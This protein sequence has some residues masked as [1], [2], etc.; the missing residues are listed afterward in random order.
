MTEGFIS[1]FLT[2]LKKMKH[3]ILYVLVSAS[4]LLLSQ[5]YKHNYIDSLIEKGNQY[6]EVDDYNKAISLYLECLHY[7]D[8][9]SSNYGLY[10]SHLNLGNIY[11]NWGENKSSLKHFYLALKSAIINKD[12]IQIAGAYNSIGNSFISINQ[13]D[14]ALANYKKSYVLYKSSDDLINTAGALNNIGTVYIKWKNDIAT[15]N[16]YFAKAYEISKKTGDI[17]LM[18]LLTLNLASNYKKLKK[19]NK[20][21]QYLDISAFYADSL[22]SKV[23]IMRIENSYSEVYEELGFYKKAYTH[24]TNYHK[25]QQDVFSEEKHKQFAEMKTKY[26][27]EKKEQEIIALNKDKELVKEKMR[28]QRILIISAISILLL[29]VFTLFMF[30]RQSKLKSELLLK[31]KQRLKLEKKN[32]SNQIEYKEREMATTTMHLVQKNEVR[33]Q[34]KSQIDKMTNEKFNKEL[35]ILSHKIDDNINAESDWETFKIHFEGVHTNFFEYLNT[36][37]PKITQNDQKICA[38]IKIGLSNKEIAQLLNILPDS[39]KS[40]KKRLKKKLNLTIDN[41]L[42]EFIK[43]I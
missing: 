39:V 43:A 41:N 32:L 37:F 25:L 31:D 35:N 29:I 2:N 3:L 33:Q 38:Y 21:L 15:G 4:I 27:T 12:S 26:E 13:Y 24:Y 17:K 34:L 7:S 28:K 8:S 1:S 18:T 10:L 5:E 42:T 9:I 22:K 36:N 23:F 11:D 14:S 30:Y 40:S 20:A 19:Y 16:K 6:S